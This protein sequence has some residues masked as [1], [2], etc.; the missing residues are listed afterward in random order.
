MGLSRSELPTSQVRSPT[1]CSC[2]LGV[3][4]LSL[5]I[6]YVKRAHMDPYE[7]ILLHLGYVVYAKNHILLSLT[8]TI[9][10]IP[11]SSPAS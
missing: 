3:L 5:L 4:G 7:K 9:I 2:V 11:E 1:I 6:D 10:S 8:H